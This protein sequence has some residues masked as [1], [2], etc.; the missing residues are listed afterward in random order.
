MDVIGRP[1]LCI[2]SFIQCNH[3]SCLCHTVSFILKGLE[4]FTVYTDDWS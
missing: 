1:L 2:S 4:S 3:L